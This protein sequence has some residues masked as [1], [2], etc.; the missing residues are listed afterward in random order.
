MTPDKPRIIPVPI[1]IH[2]CRPAFYNLN[3]EPKYRT[4]KNGQP[5]TGTPDHPKKRRWSTTLLLDPTNAQAKETIAAIKAEAARLMDDRY[6]GRANWPKANPAT[7]MGGPIW[8]FGEGNQLPKVYNGFKDMWYVKCSFTE[9][10]ADSTVRPIQGSLDGREVRLLSD[11]W[12]VVDK[13]H[14]PT[15]EKVDQSICPYAGC[16]ARARISLYTYDNES[17]GVNA[18]IISLQFVSKNASFGGRSAA[19]AD[20]EFEKQYAEY[21]KESAAAPD[22][23]A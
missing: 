16:N 10:P 3:G 5:D 20:D 6:E 13:N 15:E 14:A 9:D 21:A 8:C 7:G 1:R 19:S 11:G 23:F 22:P 4:L 17:R 12:H 2:L 18:N